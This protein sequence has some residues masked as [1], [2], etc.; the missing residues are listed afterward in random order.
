MKI[1]PW[2]VI[3]I[4]GAL[5][6]FLYAEKQALRRTLILSTIESQKQGIIARAQA[7]YELELGRKA[8]DHGTKIHGGHSYEV[9]I[10]IPV[11][12]EREFKQ[13]MQH[14]GFSPFPALSGYRDFSTQGGIERNG[15]LVWLFKI[16][17]GV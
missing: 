2:L 6:A 17:K 13:W 14:H 7:F 12:K 5:S 16:E 10:V 9:S 1:I 3:V 4:L 8:L 15:E 11:G